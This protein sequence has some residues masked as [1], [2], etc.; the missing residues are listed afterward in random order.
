MSEGGNNTMREQRI[1]TESAEP[2]S[3]SGSC[4]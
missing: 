1:D 2:P 4:L 3:Q